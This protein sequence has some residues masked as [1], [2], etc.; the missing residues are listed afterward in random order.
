MDKTWWFA[1]TTHLQVFN[2][3]VDTS[4]DLEKPTFCPWHK[5]YIQNTKSYHPARQATI[6]IRPLPPRDTVVIKDC[7]GIMWQL[8]WFD[9]CWISWRGGGEGARLWAE[10]EACRAGRR[11]AGVQQ[12]R[13]SCPGPSVAMGGRERSS[14]M[15]EIDDVNG[16]RCVPLEA[17]SVVPGSSGSPTSANGSDSVFLYDDSSMSDG[18]LYASDQENHS[19]PTNT[20][21]L[22]NYLPI[23]EIAV[24][25]AYFILT[26]QKYLFSIVHI[27]VYL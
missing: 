1:E 13:G 12:W 19:T 17:A 20:R 21:Y 7:E 15:F 6:F 10:P 4:S 23:V 14:A 18:S 26:I 24:V 25:L 16:S 5:T 9:V 8:L 22:H 2:N 27:P 3:R 11:V